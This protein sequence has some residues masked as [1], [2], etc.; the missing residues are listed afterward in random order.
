MVNNINPTASK[1]LEEI[2]RLSTQTTKK[3]GNHIDFKNNVLNT[4]SH[5]AKE[6]KR[7]DLLNSIERIQRKG[8]IPIQA[9]E[10]IKREIFTKNA[11]TSEWTKV[12]DAPKK[13]RRES[14]GSFL[15]IYL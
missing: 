5:T 8:N 10:N 11:Q 2:K 7:T 12:A 9:T 3:E 1:L 4:H 6:L 14:L 13:H 15:D